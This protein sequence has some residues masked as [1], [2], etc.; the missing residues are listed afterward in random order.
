MKTTISLVMVMLLLVCVLSGCDRLAEV[1]SGSYTPLPVSIG[2]I[3]AMT[4]EPDRPTRRITASGIEAIFIDRDHQMAWI[5]FDD[6]SLLLV[7]FV[8][9]PQETWPKGCPTNISSTRMEVLDLATEELELA[10]V[11]VERPILVRDC[12]PDPVELVLRSDGEFGGGTACVMAQTCLILEWASSTLSLPRSVKGYE[13]FSW[14]VEEEDAWYY[15][16]VTGTN[17]TKTWEE[18]STPESTITE[19]DWVKITVEGGT[20]LKSILDR[21]PEGEDVLWIGPKEPQAMSTLGD[22]IRLPNETIVREMKAYGRQL[23]INL[24]VS[25]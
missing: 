4:R 1:T 5:M 3:E 7:P 19:S 21:L 23:D 24:S 9:W 10:S 8:A 22:H 20:A 15:T 16:L 2:Q 12:P 11:T 6:A 25:D 13:L 14:Y 17:R 18:V